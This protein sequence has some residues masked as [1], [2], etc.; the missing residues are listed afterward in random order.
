MS[1][2]DIINNSDITQIG[3]S[4][5]KNFEFFLDKSKSANSSKKP[6]IEIISDE[7]NGRSI[8][9]RIPKGIIAEISA[10]HTAVVLAK[11]QATA[12]MEETKELSRKVKLLEVDLESETL[13]KNDLI[14][15]LSETRDEY[16]KIDK[17][18]A[19]E[20]TKLGEIRK[21]AELEHYEKLR[22]AKKLELLEDNRHKS[23]VGGWWS[24]LFQS[25]SESMI[26]KSESPYK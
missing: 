12:A 24:K 10:A 3:K 26:D 8:N 1:G 19:I 13:E 6:D 21:R 11:T 4:D 20:K 22:L 14:E 7:N 9:D 15:E 2:A 18:L 16:I 5:R 23:A 17:L 25:K